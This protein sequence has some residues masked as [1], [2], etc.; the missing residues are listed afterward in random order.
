M[1]E[2]VLKL[3]TRASSRSSA[4]EATARSWATTTSAFLISSISAISSI[5]S[6]DSS[7]TTRKSSMSIRGMAATAASVIAMGT[8]VNVKL[9]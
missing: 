3:P 6:M 1:W 9:P 7:G 5:S 2:P 4:A 8:Q